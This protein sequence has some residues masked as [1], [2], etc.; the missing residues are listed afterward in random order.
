[1]RASKGYKRL[2][3]HR[4]KP[5]EFVLLYETSETA[6]S[7]EVRVVDRITQALSLLLTRDRSPLR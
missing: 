6:A 1:M 5:V 2:R 4:L 7:E 3:C